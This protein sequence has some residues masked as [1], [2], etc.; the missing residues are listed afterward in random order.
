MWK[1]INNFKNKL[2]IVS[3]ATLS[4]TLL[5]SGTV[6][7]ANDVDLDFRSRNDI[8][9]YDPNHQ[10]TCPAGPSPMMPA[11]GVI[12]GPTVPTNFS[13]GTG[14]PERPLN[15][16]KNLMNDYQLTPEQAAGIIGN[17]M[18]ESGG[19]NLPPDNNEGQIPPISSPPNGNFVSGGGYGWAQWT[20][21]RKRTFL[22]YAIQH[23][24]MSSMSV[25]A[26]DGANY[27]YLKHE[28]ATTESATIPAVKRTISVYD[29]T[30]A[31]EANF[32]RAGKPAI[33]SRAAAANRLMSWYRGGPV[34]TTPGTPSP[35]PG[36]GNTNPAPVSMSDCVTSVGSVAGSTSSGTLGATTF[37][38]AN[39]RSVVT[40]SEIFSNGTTK[41][42]QHPY[43]SYNIKA[44]TG[45]P[46]LAL[47]SGTV[48]KVAQDSCPGR[49]ISIFNK[50]NNVVVSYSQLSMNASTH[51]KAGDIVKAG[52]KVG[53]IGTS[54]E[55]C[56]TAHLHI[57]AAKGTSRPNCNRQSCARE[58]AA[59]FIDIGPDLF[60]AWE[61][62][63]TSA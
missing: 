44:A 51:L 55:G 52:D 2:K 63:E 22:N 32:E 28:L 56:S 29:A 30:A 13:L 19:D 23:G 35:S 43:T 26:T 45:T 21:P 50:D 60:K 54:R 4:V 27:A 37:P 20:G 12:Q 58:D 40:N 6:V 46:V 18:H 10:L 14:V 61:G 39:A 16:M 11:T 3:A 62:L 41:K 15:L 1:L 42:S 31:F 33:D 57:D 25:P 36:G 7:L 59:K 5:M 24:Y 53:V 49:V 48:T 9:F 8:L 38:L 47:I 34:E 17:F